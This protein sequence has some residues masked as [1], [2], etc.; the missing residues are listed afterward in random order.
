MKIS[1]KKLRQIVHEELTNFNE[2]KL[3]MQKDSDLDDIVVGMSDE[4]TPPDPQSYEKTM[5]LLLSNP[6]L[7]KKGVKIIMKLS[8]SRCPKSTAQAIAHFLNRL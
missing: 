1:L 3:L 5:N 8:G 2:D 7:V 4:L 6:D